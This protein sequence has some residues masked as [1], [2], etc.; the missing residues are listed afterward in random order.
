MSR[1]NS[2]L[3]KTQSMVDC[4]P[5]GLSS[6]D[7]LL[8]SLNKKWKQKQEQTIKR[9]ESSQKL[10][11]FPQRQMSQVIAQPQFLIDH[12]NLK[13]AGIRRK[14]SKKVPSGILEVLAEERRESE[15]RTLERR[16]S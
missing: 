8:L 15:K 16:N 5:Q 11:K 3:M 14:S 12:Q 13:Q 2:G 1:V 4:R 9:K 7:M 6:Q 10:S